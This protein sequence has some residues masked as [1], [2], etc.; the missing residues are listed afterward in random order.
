MAYHK[1]NTGKEY[2]MIDMDLDTDP[3][4]LAGQF[5]FDYTWSEE[6]NPPFGQAFYT[7]RRW[8]QEYYFWKE[9]RYIKVT[10]DTVRV[11]VT[12]YLQDWAR[13]IMSTDK[14]L[15]RITKPLV[16]NVLVNIEPLIHIRETAELNSFL[17][18]FRE[19]KYVCMKNAILNLDT[20][21]LI[22][23]TPD[24]FTTVKLPFN[25]EPQAKCPKFDAFLNQ[26]MLG[27]QDYI[28]LIYEFIGYLFRPDLAEQKFLLCFGEG[29]NGKGVLF[30]VIQALVGTENCSQVPLSR[31]GDR[32][33]LHSTVGKICNM[34]NES[35]QFLEDEA[36]N[37]LKSFSAG[38][39]MTIDRKHR[40]PIEIKP[41]AKL[42]ISTNAL[43]RFNDKSQA[44]WRRVILVPFDFTVEENKQN[45][46]LA[47][48]LKE[49]LPGILNRALTGLD[50]LNKSGFTKPAGQKEL[51]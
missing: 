20:R 26:I 14:R 28:D 5:L 16:N 11:N 25:Y 7:L 48:E 39:R 31:F 47:D 22:D 17:K 1:E 9:G 44:I 13:E 49:E 29:A 18:D 8:R 24:Y 46:N 15:I 35:S 21:Q 32:F 23:H 10:E 42:L 40:E 30:E 6:E 50:R 34:T 12:E 45:K 36:E 2:A 41:T 38:D 43:P 27:R 3:M 51:M 33:A 19:G 4:A 37:I